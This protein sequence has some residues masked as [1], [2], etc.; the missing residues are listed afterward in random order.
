MTRNLMPFPARTLFAD[1]MLRQEASSGSG[2]ATRDPDNKSPTI[3]ADPMS[4]DDFMGKMGEII[5]NCTGKADADLTGIEQL[6]SHP[7]CA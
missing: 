6:Q 4:I 1:A 7:R 5:G 3:A 2:A